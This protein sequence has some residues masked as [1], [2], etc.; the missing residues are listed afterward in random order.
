ML[1]R[2]SMTLLLDQINRMMDTPSR[3]RAKPNSPIPPN[4]QERLNELEKTVSEFV[5]L[6]EQM[7]AK[8]GYQ[9]GDLEALLRNP[10]VFQQSEQRVLQRAAQLK[11]QATSA[12]HN[13]SLA[14]QAVRK[15]GN[16]KSEDP[17]KRKQER[18]KR[19]GRVGGRKGWTPM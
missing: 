5:D 14:V 8:Y 6:S 7:F 3:Q 9:K 18:Q 13:L 12:Y 11:E 15:M 10:G 19:F 1:K 17:A 4:V 16:I 2:A